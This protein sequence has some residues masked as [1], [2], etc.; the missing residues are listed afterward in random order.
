[1]RVINFPGDTVGTYLEAIGLSSRSA[2]R[3]MDDFI[4]RVNEA[5]IIELI[6]D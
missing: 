4:T 5:R 6:R 2:E 1:M 3:E